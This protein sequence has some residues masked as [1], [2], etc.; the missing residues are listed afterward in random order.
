[1]LY[2]IHLPN[3]EWSIRQFKMPRSCIN[4]LSWVVFG[5]VGQVRWALFAALLMFPH[6][7]WSMNAIIF[8][9][10]QWFKA[11]TMVRNENLRV[12]GRTGLLL[13]AN[14]S[15]LFLPNQ[16]LLN[17]PSCFSFSEVSCY[18]VLTSFPKLSFREISLG[19][20]A[21]VWLTLVSLRAA[22]FFWGN[23][24]KMI[25]LNYQR[26]KFRMPWSLNNEAKTQVKVL[27]PRIPE[28]GAILNSISA[29]SKE[30]TLLLQHSKIMGYSKNIFTISYKCWQFCPWLKYKPM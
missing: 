25:L 5:Q 27:H 17:F 9:V 24:S 3:L 7:Y 28:I 10:D 16:Q 8:S 11:C 14:Q 30:V 26:V 12:S 23:V 1:M 18:T 13:G 15:F 22:F 19:T 29:G 4:R 20:M 2:E 6:Q 21:E